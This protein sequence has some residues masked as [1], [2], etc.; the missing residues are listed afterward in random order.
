MRPAWG[1]LP[2]AMPPPGRGVAARPTCLSP[3]FR[4]NAPGARTA[5][6]D[7]G[8]RSRRSARKPASN[9]PGPG[10]ACPRAP[11][12]FPPR[13]GERWAWPCYP[14]RDAAGCEG[15]GRRAASGRRRLVAAG[16]PSWR[17]RCTPRRVQPALRTLAQG[18]AAAGDPFEA[19]GAMRAVSR[20]LPVF[21]VPGGPGFTLLVRPS[22]RPGLQEVGGGCKLS[23]RAYP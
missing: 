16:S 8:G 19:C 14:L 7:R 6:L 4:T 21:A 15:R 20:V 11:L 1:R 10:I 9:G 17:G 18:P 5:K 2:P 22:E 3:R 12:S 13:R 23:G